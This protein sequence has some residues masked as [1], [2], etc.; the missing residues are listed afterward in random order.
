MLSKEDKEKII[1]LR[2][3]NFSY[4]KIHEKLGFAIDSIMKVCKTEEKNKEIKEIH[5]DSKHIKDGDIQGEIHNNFSAIDETKKIIKSMDQLIKIDKIRATEIKELK[6]RIN[7]LQ[8]MIR[9]EVDDRITEEIEFVINNKD[10]EWKEIIK[11][12]YVEKEQITDLKDKIE[13]K[14]IEIIDLNNTIFK[15]DAEINEKDILISKFIKS[16][17][18]DEERLKTQITALTQENQTLKME[19]SNLKN[20]IDYEITRPLEKLKKDKK[21]LIDEKI[22]FSKY[23][24]NISKKNGKIFFNMVEQKKNIDKREKNLKK[25][26]SQINE[27]YNNIDQLLN[28]LNNKLISVQKREDIILIQEVI[29]KD[30]NK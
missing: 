2:S 21:D 3:K 7:Q 10:N 29:L 1:K 12:K 8:K 26:E 9:S 27:S 23:K 4:Q 17:N 18:Q 5:K 15:K 22:D 30:I 11:E 24:K 19:N 6:K 28:N 20:Y 25:Q 16:D 14:D 13:K